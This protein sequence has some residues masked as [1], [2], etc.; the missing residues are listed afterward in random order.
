MTYRIANIYDIRAYRERKPDAAVPADGNA[1]VAAAA[2]PA[3]SELMSAASFAMPAAFFTFW[4]GPPPERSRD[5]RD[6]A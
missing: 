4:P 6:G 2:P 5:D 1:D 3:K